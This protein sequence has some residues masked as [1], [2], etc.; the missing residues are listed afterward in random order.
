VDPLPRFIQTDS[1]RLR[2]ILV[3]L[4]GNAIK[5]TPSGSVVVSVSLKSANHTNRLSVQVRDTGIGMTS[6]Q[7][8]RIFQPFT[9]AESSTTRRFGGTGLGLAISRRLAQLL[10]GDISVSSIA[11]A[12]SVFTCTIGAGDVDRAELFTDAGDFSRPVKHHDIAAMD[13]AL[14]AKIL[15]AEDGRDNQ[16]LLCTHLKMAGAEVV[17]VENGKLAVDRACADSFDLILMDMQMPEMD[18]YTATGELRRRGIT[19]P[20]IALTAYAMAEDRA[21][22]LASGCDD[23]L[24]KPVAPETL[25]STI[26][27]HL[28]RISESNPTLPATEIKPEKSGP[29]DDSTGPIFSTLINYPGLEYVINEFVRDLPEMG[30]QLK[31]LLEQDDMNRLRRLAHQLRGAAGGF[32]FECI[33][34]LA[35]KTE[36]AI[37]DGQ[38][39]LAVSA[40]VSSL[41]QMIERVEVSDGKEARIAA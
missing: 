26:R 6:E 22:C 23:Y 14:S 25:L 32:G 34:E 21:K 19:T 30:Q 5:F 16:K 17:I 2:Q 8:S 39:P 33:T 11:G 12:G 31:Q 20:I 29:T 41:V 37:R 1:L 15:L 36:D 13:T 38:P 18:G 4:L 9:Q 24:S 40:C 7:S 35:A 3:N 27:H 10:D 28:G